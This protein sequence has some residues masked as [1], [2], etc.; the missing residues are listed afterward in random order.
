MASDATTTRKTLTTTLSEQ[1]I[2][3]QNNFGVT[4]VIRD[5]VTRYGLFYVECSYSLISQTIL[6][7]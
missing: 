2:A 1:T 7:Y 4:S 3:E 5:N 6:S